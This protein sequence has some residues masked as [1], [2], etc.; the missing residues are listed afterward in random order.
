LLTKPIKYPWLLIFILVGCTIGVNRVTPRVGDMTTYTV[1][2]R[3][4]TPGII[5]VR[6]GSFTK[7]GSGNFVAIGSVTKAYAADKRCVD[8]LTYKSGTVGLVRNP[9]SWYC[10]PKWA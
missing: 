6:Y 2:R 10:V 1:Y 3:S 4:A 8:Y 9:A 7:T 5:W